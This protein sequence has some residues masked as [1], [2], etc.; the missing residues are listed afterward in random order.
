MH[1]QGGP[2][3]PD[4][5]DSVWTPTPAQSGGCGHQGWAFENRVYAED[6][7]EKFGMPTIGGLYKYEDPKSIARVRCVL[8]KGLRSPFTMMTP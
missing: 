7:I 3:A 4:D 6:P 1:F 2:G 5:Q 8:R